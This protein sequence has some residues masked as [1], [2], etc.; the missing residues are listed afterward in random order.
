[1]YDFKMMYMN[2]T[3]HSDN[4]SGIHFVKNPT[5]HDH[6]K[7]IDIKYHFIR[8][9]VE[10]G[11]IIVGENWYWW[12]YYKYAYKADQDKEVWMVQKFSRLA[13]NVMKVTLGH[14]TWLEKIGKELLV[15]WLQVGEC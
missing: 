7:H 11:R 12:E 5:F 2:I 1:M 4:Q 6:N 8:K 13:K 10:E 9:V 3:M 14:G 15:Y